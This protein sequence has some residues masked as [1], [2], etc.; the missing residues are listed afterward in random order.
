MT[1]L[2][3]Y[4]DACIR[5]EVIDWH[6]E[7]AEGRRQRDGIN[8][9]TLTIVYLEIKSDDSEGS[10]AEMRKTR[11]DDSTT[12]VSSHISANKL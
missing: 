11:T 4:G 9:T 12:P 7:V 10:S 1:L 5:A 3:G 2:T 8:E 6:A